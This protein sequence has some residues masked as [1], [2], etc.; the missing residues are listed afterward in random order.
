LTGAEKVAFLQKHGPNLKYAP[1]EVRDQ[2]IAIF[3][4]NMLTPY[5]N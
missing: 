2:M 4:E 3:G 5:L 1:Q